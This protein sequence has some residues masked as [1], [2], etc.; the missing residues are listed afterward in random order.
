MSFKR[1]IFTKYYSKF[2]KTLDDYSDKILEKQVE[3]A[4]RA[5]ISAGINVKNA[6]DKTGDDWWTTVGLANLFSSF[7]GATGSSTFDWSSEGDAIREK[8]LKDLDYVSSLGDYTTLALSRDPEKARQQYEEL[9][10]ITS[11]FTKE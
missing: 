7:T 4:E 1:F 3:S 11:Q 6:V 9:S 8:Y 5:R 10:K 2:G